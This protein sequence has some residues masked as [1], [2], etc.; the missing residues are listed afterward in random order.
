ML[1]GSDWRSKMDVLLAENHPVRG[2][3]M[4]KAVRYLDTY[5]KQILRKIVSGTTDFSSLLPQTIGL[6]TNKC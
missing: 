2:E 5:W 4:K 6:S 3:L 1:N